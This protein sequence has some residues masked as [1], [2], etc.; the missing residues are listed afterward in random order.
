[1]LPLPL[2]LA[3]VACTV[4]ISLYGLQ[5]IMNYALCNFQKWHWRNGNGRTACATGLVLVY[6]TDFEALLVL[7]NGLVFGAVQRRQFS[8]LHSQRSNQGFPDVQNYTT[9]AV[10]AVDFF[11]CK[12]GCRAPLSGTNYLLATALGTSTAWCSAAMAV[13]ALHSQRS[14]TAHHW[15]GT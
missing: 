14:N 5:Q 13:S 15:A 1:M 7:W 3:H 6:G 9:L 8:A 2:A 10:K 12:P 4:R 11:S